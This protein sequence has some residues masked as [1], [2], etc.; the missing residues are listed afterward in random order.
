MAAEDTS[1]DWQRPVP[2]L[3]GRYM[4]LLGRLGGLA[5][6]DAKA[7]IHTRGGHVVPL[8]DPR[9]QTIVVGAD[10]FPF[11]LRELDEPIVERIEHGDIQ[12]CEETE[13]WQSCGLL[14]ESQPAQLY[15]P[16]MLADL[17][18]VPIRTVRRWHRLGL[19]Q[20]VKEICRLP[21]FDFQELSAARRLASWLQ[22]ASAEQ[23]EAQLAKLTSILPGARRSLSQLPIIRQGNDIL[24]RQMSGLV[25][26]NG[27]LRFDFDQWGSPDDAPVAEIF[28][29]SEHAT[30]AVEATRPRMTVTDW[31]EFK[32]QSPEDCLR[33]ALEFEDANDWAAALHVYRAMQLAFGPSAEVCFQ[34]GELLYRQGELSAARER[35]S[36][37][38]ELDAEFLE[39]RANL[40]CVLM[41]LQQW[42]LALAAFEGALDLHPDYADVLFHAAAACEKLGRTAVALDYWQHFLRVA[43]NSPWAQYA[44][45]RVGRES[46]NVSHSLDRNSQPT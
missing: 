37:A 12:L 32:P 22:T 24:L 38:V 13:F 11:N 10:S 34:I 30:E 31:T 46:T 36:M 5:K 33:Q 23:V 39:A 42:D 2:W 4:A 41:E 27:Q 28:S 1:L 17:L 29:W 8:V 14:D 25:D 7:W 21:Y 40:G 16:A 18:K 15:T 3:Q 9:V 35:Y 43:P 6:R 19:L 45:A 20:P 26:P 44:E